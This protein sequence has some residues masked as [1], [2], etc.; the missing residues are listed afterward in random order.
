MNYII[1]ATH[2][3][4]NEDDYTIMF[5]ASN[6]SEQPDKFVIIQVAKEFDEQDIELGMNKPFIQVGEQSEGCYGGFSKVEISEKKIQ[7][8]LDELGAQELKI[9]SPI[10]II[11]DSIKDF[12]MFAESLHKYILK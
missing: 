8:E 5:G 2:V 6:D 11:F 3:F 12:E 9:K 7:I 4:L 1:N 10:E